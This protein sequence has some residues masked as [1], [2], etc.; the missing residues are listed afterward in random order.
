M[1]DIHQTQGA[2]PRQGPLCAWQPTVGWEAS[3]WCITKGTLV[4]VSLTS[5]SASSGL[6]EFCLSKQWTAPSLEYSCVTWS[7]KPF[8]LNLTC[9][10]QYQ[11]PGK[12]Q[13]SCLFH[14]FRDR[15]FAISF[16]NFVSKQLPASSASVYS[17]WKK[18]YIQT[19]IFFKIQLNSYFLLLF[20]GSHRITGTWAY[21]DQWEWYG[22]WG[23]ELKL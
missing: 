15:I 17:K 12:P 6:A 13:G 14:P 19:C 18:K 8:V 3:P 2:A 1:V 22:P 5:V 10:Q 9:L 20:L 4:P 16:V 21:H 7:S 23:R 11:S